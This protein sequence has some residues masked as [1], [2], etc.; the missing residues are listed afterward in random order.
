MGKK[1]YHLSLERNRIEFPIPHSAGFRLFRYFRL[2]RNLSD[3]A[4]GRCP[5]YSASIAQI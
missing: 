4:Y 5:S 2:F 3:I 1:I